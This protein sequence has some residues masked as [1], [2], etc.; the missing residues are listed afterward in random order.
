MKVCV[1]LD[2]TSMCVAYSINVWFMLMHFVLNFSLLRMW[3]RKK[4]HRGFGK[5]ACKTPI[6]VKWG[7]PPVEVRF[8]RGARIWRQ[9]WHWNRFDEGFDGEFRVKS[10]IKAYSQ[11]RKPWLQNE[12]MPTRS[13]WNA[14]ATRMTNSVNSKVW[15]NIYQFELLFLIS[16]EMAGLDAAAVNCCISIWRPNQPRQKSF[17]KL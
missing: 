6:V 4:S 13:F 17:F 11:S 3:H 5:W 8:G 2:T 12:L 1:L 7:H 10:S 14:W 15:V 16:E 9:S